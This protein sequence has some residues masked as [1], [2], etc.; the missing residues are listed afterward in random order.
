[1]I[2]LWKTVVFEVGVQGLETHP[3]KFWFPKN[4]GKSPENPGKNS[5]QRCLTSRNGAKGLHKNTWRRF[6]GGYTKKRSL[7]SLWEKICMQ[8]LHKKFF[9]QVWG[10]S[11]KILRNQKVCL[12]LHLWW[13]GTSPPVVPL[14][15]G[16]RGKWPLHAS[17]LR[18]PCAYYS[19]R[20]LFTRCKLQCVTAMNINY[21]RSP[22]TEQFMTA[23]IQGC[24]N[25]WSNTSRSEGMP[26]GWRTPRVDS[27]LTC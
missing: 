6:C 2:L 15:K 8:K 4:L 22:K 11:G 27:L 7:L 13:K 26:L 25:V 20:T 21:Q 24:A 12:L 9:G 14:L 23:K 16:Q 17:I 18:R 19:T 5:A 3:Q 10:S 1:M